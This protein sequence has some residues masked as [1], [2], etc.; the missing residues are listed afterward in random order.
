VH[1]PTQPQGPEE[2]T[3]GRREAEGES[4]FPLPA[5]SVQIADGFGSTHRGVELWGWL[6]LVKLQHPSRCSTAPPPLLAPVSLRIPPP[7][8]LLP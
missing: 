2:K 8:P 3:V 1:L 7:R 6:L 5:G 4:W